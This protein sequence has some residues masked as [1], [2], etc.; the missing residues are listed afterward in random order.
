MQLLH[1]GDRVVECEERGGDDDCEHYKELH[2]FN[3]E[4][5]HSSFGFKTLFII[6]GIVHRIEFV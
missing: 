2:E 1:R 4:R 3:G 6:F 5:K